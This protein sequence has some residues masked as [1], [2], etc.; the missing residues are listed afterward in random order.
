MI[1]NSL[2]VTLR[3][4]LD[5]LKYIKS[6]HEKP[7]DGGQEVVNLYSGTLKK[8]DRSIKEIEEKLKEKIIELSF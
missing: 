8:L 5:T 3:N 4:A 7:H 1:G 6:L 2:Q